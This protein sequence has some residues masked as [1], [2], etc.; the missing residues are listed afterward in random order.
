MAAPVRPPRLRVV[1]ELNSELVATGFYGIRRTVRSI[2][3]SVDEPERFL[4]CLA[5]RLG[6]PDA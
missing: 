1:V 2:G 5:R 3:L 4:D 6:E